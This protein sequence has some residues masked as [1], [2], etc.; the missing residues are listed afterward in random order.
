MH[1]KG[2][3]PAMIALYLKNKKIGTY[4]PQQVRN[5]IQNQIARHGD[6]KLSP[7]ENTQPLNGDEDE[8]N[9]EDI[10]ESDEDYGDEETSESSTAVQFLRGG[11]VGK[12]QFIRHA[13]SIPTI[14]KKKLD[15]TPSNSPT[16]TSNSHHSELS[17]SSSSQ[18]ISPSQSIQAEQF[19]TTLPSIPPDVW[20]YECTAL[21]YVLIAIRLTSGMIID[22]QLSEDS[23]KHVLFT[24]Q[25]TFDAL[26]W[27]IITQFT[28]TMKEFLMEHL[29]DRCYSFRIVLKN[30]VTNLNH[31]ISSTHGL[32]LLRLTMLHHAAAQ[33][34]HGETT[35]F[36]E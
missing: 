7:M 26:D 3:K 19:R 35:Y 27:K 14:P 32:Y 2:I 24:A 12:K 16:S 23:N 20:I 18:S 1:S 15:G 9:I 31:Q 21:E 17:S 4:T 30:A 36:D 29:N 11:I 34:T 6:G 13:P 28:L 5:K 25:H 33:D 22:Y 8:V 10:D